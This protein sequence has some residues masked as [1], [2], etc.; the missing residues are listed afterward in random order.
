MRAAQF[1]GSPL[2][3]P[4][5]ILP[6][7]AKMRYPPSHAFKRKPQEPTLARLCYLWRDPN[8]RLR[9]FGVPSGPPCVANK[10]GEQ[11]AARRLSLVK[12]LQL[13]PPSRG[14]LLDSDRVTFRLSKRCRFKRA[15]RQRCAQ[16]EVRE[17]TLHDGGLPA[18]FSLNS[19]PSILNIHGLNF[20]PLTT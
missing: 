11:A 14:F 8:T 18:S 1:H 7:T 5:L 12:R 13:G 6:R 16:I 19:N 9:V 10:I 20:D 17:T 2:K 3:Y 15:Q 4:F